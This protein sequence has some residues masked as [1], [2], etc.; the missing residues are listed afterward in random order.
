MAIWFIFIALC[1]ISLIAVFS[2]IGYTAKMT[3]STPER[4]LLKH[5]MFVIVTFI[6]VIAM[7]NM[8]YRK[9]ASWSWIGYLVS[10][11][12]LVLV[13]LLGQKEN[14]AGSG[15]NRWLYVPILGRFQPSELAKIV[16]IVYLARRIALEKKTLHEWKTFRDIGIS[17]GVVI[18]LILPDNLSTALIMGFVCAVMLRLSPINVGYW[19]K[20]MLAIILLGGLAV[21]V[22]SEVKSGPL[23][24]S[25]TWTS[26]I[27]KWL[28][29]DPDE[30]TQENIARQA[31]AQGRLIGV[32]IG[33]T[34][35]ARLM[36]QAHNDFIYAIIIEE[37]GMAGGIVVFILYAILY[38]R[39]IRVAWQCKGAFGRMSAA[40]LGTLIFLQ[41][42]IHMGVSVGALPVTGQTL[43]FISYGGTAY[44]C[45]GM[46]LGVIQ[47]IAYDENVKRAAESRQ[48]DKEEK[49]KAENRAPEVAECGDQTIENQ[50]ENIQS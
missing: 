50:T 34:V 39:C 2:S 11:A 27:D 37:T 5:F 20:S 10:I 12:L 8:N 33:S 15:M 43:P 29:S 16:L 46:G 25:T 17:L 19:R 32:G 36:T 47:A 30:L 28:H 14:A 21:F 42:A 23:A 3:G 41:A 7:A 38:L 6:G 26:R 24:R 13:L 40:G 44:L 1:I 31:V 45:M 48:G 22:S 35:Q 4:A 49:R 18:A 9:F